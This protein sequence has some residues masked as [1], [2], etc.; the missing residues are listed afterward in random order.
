MNYAEKRLKEF[1]SQIKP[2]IEKQVLYRYSTLVAAESG[3]GL[4]SK[5]VAQ[6]LAISIHQA[7]QETLERVEREIKK[8][9]DENDDGFWG[10]RESFDDLLA[11]IKGPT[12]L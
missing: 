10:C 3:A 1:E 8:V 5:G 7:E 9:I 4:L 2:L 12:T 6:F 11:S